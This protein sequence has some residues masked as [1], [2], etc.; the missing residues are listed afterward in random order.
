MLCASSGRR[1]Q[2]AWHTI[3]TVT[4][5]A[6]KHLQAHA[7]RLF[8]ESLT[9]CL[10]PTAK[11]AVHSPADDVGAMVAALRTDP[12]ATGVSTLPDSASKVL[13]CLQAL[14]SHFLHETV[15]GSTDCIDDDDDG[16]GLASP[17]WLTMCAG[18]FQR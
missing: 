16:E 7:K 11:D 8:I 12:R 14:T 3:V 13:E 6:A 1:F 5:P 4:C 2:V 9:L 10:K 17:D 15:H 18:Q